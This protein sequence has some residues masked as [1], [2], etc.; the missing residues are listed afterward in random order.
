MGVRVDCIR[1]DYL[2]G[3]AKTA[4]LLIVA[5]SVIVVVPS[6]MVMLMMS[7]SGRGH[8]AGRGV[9]LY[10][11]V[12]LHGGLARIHSGSLVLRHVAPRRRRSLLRARTFLH[13]SLCG[14]GADTLRLKDTARAL[15]LVEFLL[16]LLLQVMLMM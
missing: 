5:G 9:L 7:D 14:L 1:G 6:D 11:G 8:Q 2:L 10:L 15:N 13:G 3:R 4:A 12:A 16:M